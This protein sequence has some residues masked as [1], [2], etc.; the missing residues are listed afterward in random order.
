MTIRKT[1]KAAGRGTGGL[2]SP[3]QPAARSE[4]GWLLKAAVAVLQKAFE[5][6]AADRVLQL[7]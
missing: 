6:L 1:K 4:L 5:L 3:P 2:A 7:S